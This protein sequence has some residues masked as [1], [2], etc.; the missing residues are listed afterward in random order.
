[1][2]QTQTQTQG[3]IT[4]EGKIRGGWQGKLSH[5]YAVV[6]TDAA[7]ALVYDDGHARVCFTETGNV[8]TLERSKDTTSL[9]EFAKDLG[10]SFAHIGAGVIELHIAPLFKS[11]SE[12]SEWFRNVGLNIVD[13]SGREE[14]RNLGLEG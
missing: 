8:F 10:D 3:L 7:N 12:A 2:T 1:M 6:V 13:V 11:D 4:P 5:L 14:L 9:R